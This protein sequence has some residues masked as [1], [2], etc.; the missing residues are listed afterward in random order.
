MEEKK[1]IIDPSK[2]LDVKKDPSDMT[3]NDYE[4][5]DDPEVTD[6][7]TE[8]A[9]RI[10]KKFLPYHR[11]IMIGGFTILIFLVVY[12]G[13]AYGGLKVCSDLDGLLDKDFKCHPNYKP[14]IYDPLKPILL[15]PNVTFDVNEKES[16]G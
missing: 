10:R 13:Y 14:D 4:P 12:L 11:Y 2:V 16:P 9:A 3:R 15:N 5:E 6:D 7:W 1:P 8:E